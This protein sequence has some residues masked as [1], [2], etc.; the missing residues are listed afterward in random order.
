MWDDHDYG[1]NDGD[2]TFPNKFLTRDIFLDFVAEP[3]N[4][5]RRVDTNSSIHQDYL[6]S[7]S[8]FKTHIILLDNRFSFDKL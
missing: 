4:S 7:H 5:P 8:N 3:M 6:I 2:M 1:T